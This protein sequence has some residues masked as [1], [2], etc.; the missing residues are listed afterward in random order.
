MTEAYGALAAVYEE[1]MEDVPYPLWRD[2]ITG[3][4]R[5]NG[6][7]D[8]LVLELGCGTGTFTRMLSE[9]GY[10]M[11]GLDSSEE[12]LM[13]AQEREAGERRGILY[14][15]Q[16]MQEMELYGTVRA[17]VSVCDSMNYLTE[18]DDLVRVMKLANNYLDPDG[19]FL[20]DLRT[21]WFYRTQMGDRTFAETLDG[22]AYIWENRFDE[23][24]GLNEYALTLFL[25]EEPDVYRRYEELHL[26]RA[27]A[28]QQIAAA[29]EAA[30]L[31]LEGIL[32]METG[33]PAGE[34]CPRYLCV[35]REHGKAVRE[36]KREQEQ[37]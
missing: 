10:D 6:I 31:I 27:Y 36:R 25:E 37:A 24:E 18:P 4:L 14:L 5:D 11:I 17:I 15:Q 19:L 20:F 2:R 23:A 21:D 22:A 29:A 33:R 16:P 32:D 13:N 35:L 8:G 7:R 34:E 30:G 3:I 26:Q 1:L 28:P 9:A 12:M